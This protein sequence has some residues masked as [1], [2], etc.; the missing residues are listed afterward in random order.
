MD[1]LD[2]AFMQRALL[3]AVSAT[4]LKESAGM[5]QSEMREAY[6]ALRADS[7]DWSAYGAAS[8]VQVK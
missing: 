6:R 2:Y 8:S 5:S 1:L 3:A 4:V 7:S